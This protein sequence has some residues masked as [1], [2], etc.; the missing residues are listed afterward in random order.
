MLPPLSVH[1]GGFNSV[2]FDQGVEASAEHAPFHTTYLSNSLPTS[3]SL[4]Q[5]HQDKKKSDL[6]SPYRPLLPEKFQRVEE[7]KKQKGEEDGLFFP[8]GPVMSESQEAWL[9]PLMLSY[10]VR[11]H[12]WDGEGMLKGTGVRMSQKS[13][14]RTAASDLTGQWGHERYTAG[15]AHTTWPLSPL[16]RQDC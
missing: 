6:N 9:I 5:V 10:C 16:G 8:V 14:V 2:S 12:V 4:S 13:L 15:R 11:V 1:P 3:L 7:K